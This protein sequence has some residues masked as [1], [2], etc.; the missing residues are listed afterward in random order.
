MNRVTIGKILISYLKRIKY[1]LMGSKL[2]FPAKICYDFAVYS[3]LVLQNFLDSL[4]PAAPSN[5]EL[6]NELTIVVKTFERYK[7]LAR[8]LRSIRKYYPSVK[9]VVVDDS[10]HPKEVKG[11]E[12]ITMPYNSGISAGRNAALGCVATKYTLFLDDDFVFSRKTK[13]EDSLYL[14]DSD[15]RID[16]LGGKVI[17]LPFF[18]IHDYSKIGLYPTNSQP[19]APIGSKISGLPVYDKVPNFFICRTD[20]V[21]KVGWDN[22]L[23]KIE[24]ADFF[25]RARGVLLTVYDEKF[26]CLHAPTPFDGKY[27][28]FRN[29]C[30]VE[31][32]ILIKKYFDEN[33]TKNEK[34]HK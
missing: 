9:I 17:D 14:I 10:L 26:A 6:L 32:L 24:H 13:I 28:K 19:V 23:K 34:Q 20:R 31:R 5:S 18:T 27:M 3:E 11:V 30:A 21:K 16:I 22:Q 7:T 12:K 33:S 2:Q 8:L 25:T 1:A 15:S 29:D 4:K